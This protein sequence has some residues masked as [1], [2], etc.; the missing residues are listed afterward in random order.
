VLLDA[1]KRVL[2]G[3]APLRVPTDR[4]ARRRF[5]T[6][7]TAPR[8]AASSAPPCRWPRNDPSGEWKVVIGELL[9]NTE[10][11]AKFSYVPPASFGA[12]AGSVPRAVTFG[13]DR[14]NIF[15]FF[16]THQDVTLVSGKGD[17]AAAAARSPR[18]SSPGASA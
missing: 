11:T 3:S 9:A 13:A 15:R 7:S 12:L 8:N 16:R 17:Y 10:D 18:C 14:E 2:A 5:D 1:E 4:S 6:T